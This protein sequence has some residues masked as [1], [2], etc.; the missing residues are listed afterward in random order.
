MSIQPMDLALF[1]L[2]NCEVIGEDGEGFELITY[3]G[4][5][6]LVLRDVPGRLGGVDWQKAGY[7]VFD[8]LVHEEWSVGLNVGFWEE[9]NLTDQPSLVFV[10]GVLP[11]VKTRIAL[12]LS[13]LNSQQ[14]FQ[15]RTP[16]RLKTVI[17]GNKVDLAA[18][19]QISV[20]VQL[21]SFT[22][23][24]ALTNFH[25]SIDEPEYP[26]AEVKLVDEFGQWT[27]KNWP[28]KILSESELLNHLKSIAADD[29]V[30]S[31]PTDWSK[32][33]GWTGKKFDA[34]GYF[35]TQKVGET[36]WLVDPEGNAFYSTG[37][38]CV[39]PD[40]SGPVDGIEKWF[41]WLPAEE[42][43]YRDAWKKTNWL[44]PSS[45]INFAAVNL[46]RAFG[47]TW[48]ETWTNL[49]LNQMKDW[50]F[51]TVGNWSSQRFALDSKLPYVYPLEDFPQTSSLI[52]RDFPDV[53]SEEYQD[54]STRFALQLH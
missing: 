30:R 51:N 38:D 43:I 33:G 14:M 50:G 53:F 3:P 52:F 35:R 6:G 5:A 26:L 16:G 17:H 44:Q 27:Q 24:L 47:E 9:S 39:R 28:G 13:E 15:G 45:S 29:R 12:P 2:D 25:L 48:W 8:V 4:I 1:A 21:S 42:G 32:Y 37:L 40:E 18:V 22:Q 7:L 41:T 10:I 34:T 23:K 46:I 19:N 49:T 36:W 20:G 54:N 31:F 11:G